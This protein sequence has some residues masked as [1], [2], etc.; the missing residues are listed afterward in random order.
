MKYLTVILSLL[1]LSLV[2]AAELSE[3][4]VEEVVEF[5]SDL[6]DNVTWPKSVLKEGN[7]DLF[8]VAAL[9]KTALT[10]KVIGLNFKKSSAGHKIKVR[11]VS[12]ELL[13]SNAHVL[14][15]DSDDKNQVA[16]VLKAIS[17]TGT[18][19][20]TFNKD[21]SQLGSMINLYSE[22]SDGKERLKYEINLDVIAS[23]K[24]ELKKDLI[25]IA[26]VIGKK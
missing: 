16:K 10:D 21:F 6:D 12:E 13:P 19:T 24:I 14:L 23:E 4:Q 17:G 26:E 22:K 8:V 1:A 2:S 9:G 25:E 5:V 3:S 11:L 15:I 7:G 18:L 20:V